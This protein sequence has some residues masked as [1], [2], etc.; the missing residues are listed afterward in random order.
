MPLWSF[1]KVSGL[2]LAITGPLR[3]AAL[4]WLAEERL[5]MKLRDLLTM[6]ETWVCC[7]C[8][9]PAARPYRWVV[10]SQLPVFWAWGLGSHVMLTFQP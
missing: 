4:S 1:C 6:H 3:T 7:C 8:I 9:S 10:G 2:F 5:A